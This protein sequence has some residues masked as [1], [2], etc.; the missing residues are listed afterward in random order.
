MAVALLD[1]EVNVYRWTPN[2][3][4]FLP[5][6]AL[7]NLP[8]F[9]KGMLAAIRRFV[10]EVQDKIGRSRG[11]SAA[12]AEVEKAAGALATPADRW[13]WDPGVS[14]WPRSTAEQEYRQAIRMLRAYNKRVAEGKAAYER[15]ADNLISILERVA[16]DIGSQSDKIAERVRTLGDLVLDTRSDDLYYDTKGRLYGYAMILRALG[17]DFGQ[18][19]EEKRAGKEWARMLESL[20]HAAGLQPL[21]VRNGKADSLLMPSHL[22][23]QGFFLL[24]A[25]VQL[26]EVVDILQR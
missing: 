15:R 2:D 14:I 26:K 20:S 17:E 18:V 10:I 13:V 8:N 5:S 21:L 25:R 3:P 19:I 6:Y 16:D 23:A 11:S 9:Q 4:F 7:D 24:R 1:R 12:D 22:A